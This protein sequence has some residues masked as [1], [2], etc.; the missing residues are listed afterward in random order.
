MKNIIVKC[1]SALMALPFLVFFSGPS[2]DST[3]APQQCVWL[4]NQGFNVCGPRGCAPAP[5]IAEISAAAHWQLHSD[6][7]HR[8]VSSQ[9]EPTVGGGCE[10]QRMLRI[11]C[12]GN[13][14]GVYQIFN[15]RVKR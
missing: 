8:R 2:P 7:N 10:G 4:Q 3:H 11:R 15:P 5:A 6:N 13:E 12:Q 1:A 9:L 14:S